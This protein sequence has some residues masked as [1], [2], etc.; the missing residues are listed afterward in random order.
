MI[1]LFLLGD[2]GG[3]GHVEVFTDFNT[4]FWSGVLRAVQAMVAAA[5]FLVGGLVV[6]GI[7]RGIVGADRMR[8][9]LGVGHWSGPLRAWALGMLLPICSLG[10]LPVARELRR[11]GVPSGTVLS[12][13]LVAPMLNPVSIIYGLSHI[14]PS[15]LLFFAAGTFFVSVGI[16][17]IWNRTVSDKRDTT[18]E[19]LETPPGDTRGR[20]AVVGH[21]SATGLVGPT[22]VD[23][24]LALLAVGLL[25]AFLPHEA[26]ESGLTRDNILAPLI[27]GLVAFPVYVTPFEAMMHF[28]HIVRDGYSLGAAFALLVLGAGANVGVANWLRRDYG[29]K[30]LAFFFAML[31]GSTVV[32]GVIADRTILHGNADATDHTHAFDSF[33]RLPNVA[34]KNANVMWIHSK[35]MESMTVDKAVGLALLALLAVA[36]VALRLSGDRCSIDHLLK[37][38]E[39]EETS[40]KSPGW[41]PALSASQLC[42]VGVVC[43]LAAATLGLYIYYPPAD[44]LIDDMDSISFGVY[45]A[46]KEK[47]AKEAVRCIAQWR[48][49]VEKLPTSV[50]I[51]FETV[52]AAQQASV[53]EMLHSLDTLEETMLEGRFQ[54]ASVLANH[55]EKV[56]R[57]CRSTFR[58]R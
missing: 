28:G 42:I 22:S 50:R 24:V 31:I 26:L 20:L 46:V 55:L 35:V 38:R 17:L 18:P 43:V 44:G 30:L 9:I 41:N 7:L 53:D 12:F 6:A 10:V 27:M 14:L 19:L 13:V 8:T 36:G 32:I 58:N 51:R 15:L 2:A 4:T 16:G 48:S 56:Y 33:G 37:P 45:D 34:D 52:D 5:P 57:S 21:T 39:S 40:T 25:G 3:H 23:Y 29:L 47:D 1:D 11:A 49:Q 54:E